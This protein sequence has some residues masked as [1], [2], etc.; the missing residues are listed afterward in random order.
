M[1]VPTWHL[2]VMM[3][4][5]IALPVAAVPLTAR[6]VVAAVVVPVDVPTVVATVDPPHPQPA[7]TPAITP[8]RISFLSFIF[9]Y[10]LAA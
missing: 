7:M 1:P 6:S 9:Y 5:G 10:F 3:A 2:A 4:P 8:V